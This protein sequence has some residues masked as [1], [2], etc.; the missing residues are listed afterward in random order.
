MT[1]RGLR[2]SQELADSHS[3]SQ[4]T[5]ALGIRRVLPSSLPGKHLS[6]AAFVDRPC[7][8]GVLAK[9]LESQSEIGRNWLAAVCRLNEALPRVSLALQVAPKETPPTGFEVLS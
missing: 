9:S 2:A 7:V 6:C 1:P 5:A 3:L 4:F 8:I